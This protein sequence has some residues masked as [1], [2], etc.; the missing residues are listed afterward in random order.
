MNIWSNGCYDIL[1][2]GHIKLFEYAKSI[3]DSLIIGIDS[4]DRIKKN[5]GYNRPINNQEHR[6]TVLK[7]IKYIDRV[8]I[9]NSDEELKSLIINNNIDT[10]VIGDDY[11]NKNVIGSEL[12]ESVIFFP[13]IPNIST[14]KILNG[15][16]HSST[17]D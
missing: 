9:F 16:A 4:D 5:K 12:V 13:K 15:S 10:I 17:T 2:I 6:K 1:H 14:T 11:I 8:Y 7:S 3:G